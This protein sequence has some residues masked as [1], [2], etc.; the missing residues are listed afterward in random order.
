M[1]IAF[2]VYLG[3]FGL[4]SNLMSL[5]DDFKKFTFDK[6]TK[7]RKSGRGQHMHDMSEKNSFTL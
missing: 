6:H 2:C 5:F 7:S 4:I 3:Y 1:E